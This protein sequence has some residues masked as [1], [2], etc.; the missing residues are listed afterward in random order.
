MC[1][2]QN[3]WSERYDIYH[4]ASRTGDLRDF[5]FGS[6]VGVKWETIESGP[7]IEMMPQVADGSRA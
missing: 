4:A 3:R 7:G 5:C 1:Y 6:E 2:E